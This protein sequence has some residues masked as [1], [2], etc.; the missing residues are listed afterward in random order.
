MGDA[1][2][3]HKQYGFGEGKAWMFAILA[4]VALNL[5]FFGLMPGL[6]ARLPQEQPSRAMTDPVRL[7]Q[8]RPPEPE[9]KMPTL[10]K[11]VKTAAQTPSR[12]TPQTAVQNTLR[13]DI[14]P[15]PLELNPALPPTSVA[16]PA[17]NFKTMPLP[18]VQFQGPFNE[19]DLDSPAR[20]LTGTK[21]VYP[22]RARR[23]NVEGTVK[24]RFV[25]TKEGEIR[26]LVIV[27][28]NPPG[29]FEDATLRTITS[30]WRFS[31]GKKGGQPADAVLVREIRFQM[32]E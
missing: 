31:L 12:A 7:T 3:S 9:I 21:P 19:S 4:A 30:S 10:P 14:G 8:V 5:L 24:V 6:M 22:L 2:Q 15:L 29:Y 26:D 18:A 32:G 20:E 1:T 23:M 11:E 16:L 27:E 25:L 28:A 17:P 13:T